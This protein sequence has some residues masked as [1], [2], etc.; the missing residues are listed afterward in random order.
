M[1]DRGDLKPASLRSVVLLLVVD[2][3]LAWA[4]MEFGMSRRSARTNTDPGI[5]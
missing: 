3:L 2:T 4:T 1:L 5:G